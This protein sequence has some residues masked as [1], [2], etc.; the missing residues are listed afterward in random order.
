M[1]SL[2]QSPEF[3]EAVQK[4]SKKQYGDALGE[5]FSECCERLDKY[6]WFLDADTPMSAPVRIVEWLNEGKDDVVEQALADFYR[7]RLSEIEKTLTTTFPNRKSVLEAAFRAHRNR[8]YNLSI[9]T[10]LAQADGL[11]HD[12]YQ[13]LFFQA[14]KSIPIAKAFLEEKNAD[15]VVTAFAYPLTHQGTI[16]QPTHL[17]PK[18]SNLL[19]RHTILHGMSSDYGTEINSLKCISLL[20][21]LHGFTVMMPS[22]KDATKGLE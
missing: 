7:E 17:L 15:A 20:S 3:M 6:S 19:N 16:R 1:E 11:S 4:L 9:P 8:D 10:F 18:G 14:K 2:R 22:N 12:I 5:A 21:H 13:S